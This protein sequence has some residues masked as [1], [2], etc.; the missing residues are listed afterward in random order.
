MNICPF[1]KKYPLFIAIKVEPIVQFC[2][3]FDIITDSLRI[4]FVKVSAS[5]LGNHGGLW[6][7]IDTR[8]LIMVDIDFLIGTGYT[9]YVIYQFFLSPYQLTN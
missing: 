6:I 4:F 1:A 7:K 5:E 3:R 9:R 8:Y 2:N